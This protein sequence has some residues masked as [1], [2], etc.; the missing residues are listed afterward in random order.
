VLGTALGPIA[1]AARRLGATVT[2][3]SDGDLSAQLKALDDDADKQSRGFRLER[4]IA[5]LFRANR[6]EVKLNPHTA[7]P[8][9][10]DL[11][12]VR[13]VAIAISSSASGARPRRISTTSMPF[14]RGCGARSVRPVDHQCGGVL[15]HRYH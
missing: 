13:A 15:W 11:V 10:T 12:V 7:H 8:R 5:D 4:V 6:F 14:V 2:F 1:S 3:S 9:Q